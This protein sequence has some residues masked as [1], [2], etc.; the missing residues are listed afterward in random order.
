[1]KNMRN[2][3]SLSKVIYHSC[4][5]SATFAQLWLRCLLEKKFQQF[6]LYVGISVG[7]KE[8]DYEVKGCTLR[9]NERRKYIQIC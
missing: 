6:Y 9:T 3:E 8:G 4:S 2:N 1:M 7:T 5:P